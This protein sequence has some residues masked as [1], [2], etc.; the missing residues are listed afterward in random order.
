MKYGNVTGVTKPISRLVQGTVMV[1]ANNADYSFELLDGVFERGCNTFDTA[2]VYGSGDNE[3]GV[4][5]WIRSRGIREQVVILAKGAHPYGG[6]PHRVTPEDITTDL[7]ETLERLGTDY[8]D[9]YVLHRDDPSYPVRSIVEILNQHLHAGLIKA[10]GGSNWTHER[11]QQ[12]KDYALAAGLVPFAVSSPNY[13]LAEQIKEPWGGCV[14]ISGPNNAEA[15]LW[16][17]ENQMPVFAWSSLAG[18][19]FSGRLNRN[20]LETFEEYLD[21]LA[22]EC[23]ANEPNFERLERAQQL[24]EKK[25]LTI[26]QVATAWV[27]SGPLNV[28]ALVGCRSADEFRANAAA[29]DVRLTAEERAWLDLGGQENQAN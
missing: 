6:K 23:Y 28:F 10:F 11:L 25:G 21:K 17:E 15:R 13:S 19:F 12:A 22:V 26:P 16:Y 24:G 5:A 14:T 20:N 29:L 3:R 7:Y 18:G 4:G 8:V 1:G 2:H 27:M 9:L